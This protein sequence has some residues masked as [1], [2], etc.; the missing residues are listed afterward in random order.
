MMEQ[1]VN[2]KMPPQFRVIT[3][4]SAVEKRFGLLCFRA[5]EVGATP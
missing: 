1:I 5:L 2:N 4:G 3:D